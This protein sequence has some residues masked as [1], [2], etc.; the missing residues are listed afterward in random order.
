MSTIEIAQPGLSALRRARSERARQQRLREA[1]RDDVMRAMSG[2]A[3]RWVF[4]SGGASAAFDF[5][6]APYGTCLLDLD[7]LDLTTLQTSSVS[8]TPVANGVALGRWADKSGNARHCDQGTA[9]L[10]PT[11][12]DASINGHT[13][14]SFV[15]GTRLLSPAFTLAQP[16]TLYCVFY[17]DNGSQRYLFDGQTGLSRAFLATTSTDLEGYAGAALHLTTAAM[18]TAGVGCVV[19]NSTSSVVRYNASETSGD[20]GTAT[21]T[22]GLIVGDYISGG[23][24]S[25]VGGIGRLLAY[26][27]AHTLA[28]RNAIQGALR[29]LWGTP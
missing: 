4:P 10:R 3:P 12:N 25:M 6:A 7:A 17:T 19:F 8:S 16:C 14:V 26:G 21:E 18:G 11:R 5:H 2:W 24:H 23:G 9:G 15:S 29:A 28:Q 1:P 27:A 20:L 22:A 13:S